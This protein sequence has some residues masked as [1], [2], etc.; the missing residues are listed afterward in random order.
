MNIDTQN[1]DYK[2]GDIKLGNTNFNVFDCLYALEYSSEDEL[3]NNFSLKTEKY[4]PISKTKTVD[5]KNYLI[6]KINPHRFFEIK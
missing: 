4:I 3:N 5:N 2:L 6:F 1:W